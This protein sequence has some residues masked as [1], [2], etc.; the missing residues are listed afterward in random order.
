M[1][2]PAN[3]RQ[4][5][6]KTLDESLSGQTVAVVSVYERDRLLMEYLEGLGVRPGATVHVESRNYDDTLT[7]RVDGKSV[8]LGQAAAQKVWVKAS[9]N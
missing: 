8:P 5:G 2:T 6:L 7:L 3:R 1:D 9:A 4:R